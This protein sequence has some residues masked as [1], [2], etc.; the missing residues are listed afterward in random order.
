M[1]QPVLDSPCVVAVICQL[2]AAGVP[3]HVR[4]DLQ[5]QIGAFAD[6]LDKA[7]DGVRR[8]RPSPLGRKHTRTVVFALE[9]VQSP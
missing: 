7:I 8:E 1:T 3:Q 5:G 6:A 2:V 4:M 9:L